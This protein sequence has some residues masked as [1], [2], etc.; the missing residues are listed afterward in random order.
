MKRCRA[1]CLG[2]NPWSEPIQIEDGK[3]QIMS[4]LKASWC[5]DFCSDTRIVM[6]SMEKTFTKPLSFIEDERRKQVRS[7]RRG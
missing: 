4:P 3:V 1:C 5:V 6:R 7:R 2:W